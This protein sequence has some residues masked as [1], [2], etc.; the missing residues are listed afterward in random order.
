MSDTRD[1]GYILKTI[2]RDPPPVDSEP[3]IPPG[4]RGIQALWR[5][6]ILQALMDAAN[7]SH[8]AEIRHHRHQALQWLTLHQRDFFTVCDYAGLDPQYVCRTVREALRRN[9]QWR[10]PSGAKA[11]AAAAQEPC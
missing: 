6:V 5:A 9:C 2:L 10:A 7:R 3:A 4:A 8:K 11:K 1:S